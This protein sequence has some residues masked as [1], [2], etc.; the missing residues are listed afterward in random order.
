[1][2]MEFKKVLVAYDGSKDSNNAVEAACALSKGKASV[3]LLHVYAI[4]MM[5]YTGRAGL[6]RSTVQILDEGA[7]RTAEAV[8]KKGLNR[9][10]RKGVKAKGEVMESASTVETIVTYASSEKFDLIVIGTRGNAGFRRLLVGSVSSGV[11]NHA[12]CPVL[13]VR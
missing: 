1:M 10:A 9:A 12:H 6:P 13:L 3:T 8:V 2:T 5:V 7:K 4:P 11:L